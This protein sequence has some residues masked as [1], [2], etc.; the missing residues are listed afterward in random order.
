MKNRRDPS[1][2]CKNTTKLFY[3]GR[4]SGENGLDPVVRQQLC[5][6]RVGPGR[7]LGQHIL[8]VVPSIV[9]I[10]FGQIDQTHKSGSMFAR[11]L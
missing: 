7:Q 5:Q 6:A 2:R 10:Q 11:L 4:Q 1:L 8:Q 9:T 3:R